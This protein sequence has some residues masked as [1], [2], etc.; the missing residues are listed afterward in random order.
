ME[1]CKSRIHTGNG[2]VKRA[3]LSNYENDNVNYVILKNMPYFFG[4]RP[5]LVSFF[6][7]DFE[8][9]CGEIWYATAFRI[10][11]AALMRLLIGGDFFLEKYGILFF[12]RRL[13][14]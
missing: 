6:R 4:Y 1:F 7:G 2:A 8:P 5:R 11:L 13:F 9:I 14:P 3:T 10:N 12:S